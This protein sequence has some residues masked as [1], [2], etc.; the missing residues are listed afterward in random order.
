MI[1]ILELTL[2]LI[3]RLVLVLMLRLWLRL[4]VCARREIGREGERAQHA[5]GGREGAGGIGIRG[6]AG[7]SVAWGWG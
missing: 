7:T 6:T 2:R 5:G 3:L 4:E 1:L